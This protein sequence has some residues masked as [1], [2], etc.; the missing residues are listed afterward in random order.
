VPNINLKLID[1][2][3][4]IS[5]YLILVVIVLIFIFDQIV[6]IVVGCIF[7]L[8]YLIS[9][10]I[11]LSSKKR[12]LRL[13]ENNLIISDQEIADKI[14]SPLDEVRKTLSRLAKNQKKKEWLVVFLNNRYIFLN[15]EGVEK[16]KHYYE[17]GFNEKNIL[18]SL[19]NE[20]NINSRAE[21]RAIQVTLTDLNRL[22]Y[23][24]LDYKKE[25]QY[26]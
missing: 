24:N 16:F 19:K 17:Q 20:M 14:Q 5:F 3:R 8:I 7:F 10:S 1:K 26:K 25:Q 4:K 21:V 6:A 13:I 23:S 18:E 2:L 12:L 11:N 15:E 22:N 9:Y